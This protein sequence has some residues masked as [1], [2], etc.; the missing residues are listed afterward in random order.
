MVDS[1]A[2]GKHLTPKI[3]FNS[4]YVAESRGAGQHLMFQ[5]CFRTEYAVDSR[6]EGKTEPCSIQLSL[7]DLTKQ[8]VIPRSPLLEA[9]RKLVSLS[10]WCI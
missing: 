8:G 3:S 6:D 7:L 10:A 9:D 1:S 4:K 5:C 2:T